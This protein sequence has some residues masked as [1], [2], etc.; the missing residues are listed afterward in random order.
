MCLNIL[1]CYFQA[2]LT[3]GQGGTGAF[4]VEMQVGWLCVHPERD[5]K[6]ERVIS[7]TALIQS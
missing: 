1:P 3:A 6:K 4:D 7:H 2:F 5:R